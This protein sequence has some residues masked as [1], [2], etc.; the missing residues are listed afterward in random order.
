MVVKQRIIGKLKKKIATTFPYLLPAAFEWN[1]RQNSATPHFGTVPLPP[2]AGV[3]GRHKKNSSP[4]FPLPLCFISQ[5]APVSKQ[6]SL[7][8]CYSRDPACTVSSSGGKAAASV[9]SF[10]RLILDS[11]LA[12]FFRPT[13]A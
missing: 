8:L 4:H 1:R 6:R 9:A 2:V 12:R 5:K 3:S 11:V 13:S 10:G 7:R